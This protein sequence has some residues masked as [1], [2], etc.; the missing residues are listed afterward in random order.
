MCVELFFVPI[1][2]WQFPK[3]PDP[4]S[5][6][7]LAVEFLFYAE[8]ELGFSGESKRKY[9]ECL[10]QV[11][12]LVG[13]RPIS[14]FATGDLLRIRSVWLGK[15]LSASRQSSL[16]L[17]LR[18]FLLFCRDQKKIVLALDPGEIKPPK[19]PRREVIFLTPEEI[20]NFVATIRVQTYTGDVHRAGL[21]LRAIVEV[22]LGSAM[23]ISEALS[24][25]R[26][27]ID[28]ERREARIIGKGNK[29]RTVFF[30]DRALRWVHHYLDSREDDAQALFVCQ[31]NRDRLKRD[32]LWR[33]FERHRKLAGINK[34]LTPHILRH[35]AATQ[36]LFNGCPVG[37][38]KT[39]LGHERL[40]TT[41]RYYLGLDNRQAKAAH[42][43]YL[44]YDVQATC[45]DSVSGE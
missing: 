20:E 6:S 26:T 11:W 45:D 1:M 32:D 13:D 35:T 31:N 43:K 24:L 3:N 23:R 29:E 21:R 15:Q 16:L 44:S 9:G 42:H 12:L 38:I 30:T 10:K 18:R 40:E 2:Q 33:Y 22:L 17:S 14:E 41:C 7:A 5:F 39:I 8:V 4:T 37:H 25:D 28:F 36:L 19:R 34:R 27:S